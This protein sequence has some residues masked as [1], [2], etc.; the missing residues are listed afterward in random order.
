MEFISGKIKLRDILLDN[1]NWIRFFAAYWPSIRLPIIT[2]IIKLLACRTTFFGYTLFRCPKCD[3]YKKVPHTCKSRFCPS[4]GKKA[5]DN[6]IQNSYEQLP[7]C[8]YQ[9]IT[10]TIP[11]QLWDLFWL[12]RHL[13]NIA[14]KI[15]ADIIMKEAAKQG[16]LPGIFLAIHTFGRK[17]NRN[18]HLHMST[19]VGGLSIDD[20]CRWV[21]NDAFFPHGILKNEWKKSILKLLE[22]E[23]EAG[24]LKLP[25]DVPFVRCKYSFLDWVHRIKNQTWIVH[26]S[27]KSD[28]MKKNVDYLGKYLKRPP[29]GETRILRYDGK[30]VTFRYLDHYTKVQD[31]ITLGV[32]EFIARLISHIPDKYFR[33][34]RYYGFLSNRLRGK[35]LPVAKSSLL[36]TNKGDNDQ[37]YKKNI[38]EKEKASDNENICK[39]K[40][41]YRDLH[42]KYTGRDPLVCLCCKREMEFSYHHFTKNKPDRRF[43]KNVALGCYSM[44]N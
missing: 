14:P 6:W 40:V 26:L 1:F 35:L 42:K 29:V 28:D 36:P 20:R 4:C 38:F 44:R 12:N 5:T 16:Y 23:F 10:F 19:T 21:K 32:L 33:N 41:S 22:D 43:H 34:I 39:Q 8:Q 30:E 3:T 9:H 11:E 24:R 18:Y 25:K 13:M 15:A 27:E 7:Q 31:T 17:A 37:S 2:N